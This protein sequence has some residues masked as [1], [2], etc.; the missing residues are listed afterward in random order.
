MKVS[1]VICNYNYDRYLPTAIKSVLAQTYANY[2]IIVVDDG[3]RDNSHQVLNE[4][5]AQLPPERFKVIFQENQGH[6]GAINTGFQNSSGEIVATLDSDDV[7]RSTKLEKV[8]R[9]FE[10][11]EVVGAIH[12]LD[13]IDAS[14]TITDPII[15]PFK[16][17]DGHLAE[18]LLATGGTWRYTCGLTFRRTA[19]QHILPMNP[20]EWRFWPDGCLLYCAAFLGRVI[21]VN[22]ALGSYRIH[23]ANTF[24]S[25]AQ[26]YDRQTKAVAGVEITNQWLNQFLE[27]IG[28]PE[29]VDLSRN[30]DH[31]RAKYYLKGKWDWAEIQDIS[32]LIL[33]WHF[34]TCQ[35]KMNY[36]IRFW[37]KSVGFLIRPAN[38]LE[39]TTS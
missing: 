28:R 23:G 3:S 30:L 4:F 33:N 17:P 12:P 37:V 21:A 34:Y 5:Q 36:L 1:V 18:V 38:V 11:P 29:R 8:V 6:G 32:Q 2:E 13:F 25:T 7:W 20:P 19:L 24:F 10:S 39:K 35:E 26:T 31:R 22:E 27:R 16:I 14:G 9:A 15:T